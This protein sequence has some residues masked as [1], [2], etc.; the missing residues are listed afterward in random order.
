MDGFRQ[1]AWLWLA[2]LLGGFYVLTL[3][4]APPR[5]GT[6]ATI[7][8]LI[9][10]QLISAAVIDSIGPFGDPVRFGMARSLGVVMLLVGA[11]LVLRR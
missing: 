6:L 10:G 8:L 11:L 3:T 1:P 4:Y 9:V 2:G 5:I 7:G